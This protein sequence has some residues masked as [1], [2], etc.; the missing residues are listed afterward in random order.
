MSNVT[1]EEKL[2]L[3]PDFISEDGSVSPNATILFSK[4]KAFVE[5]YPC[6]NSYETND[7][8]NYETIRP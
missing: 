3:I 2:N 6:N 8:G 5:N 1:M 7:I 4:F